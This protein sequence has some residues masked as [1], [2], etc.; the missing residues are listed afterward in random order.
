MGF[1]VQSANSCEIVSVSANSYTGALTA[2][3]VFKNL[4]TNTSTTH[5]LTYS[6]GVGQLNILTSSLGS[7]TGVFEVTLLEGGVEVARRPLLLHCD[8]DC[9]LAKLTNEI[10]DCACDCPKCSSALAKAQ[11]VFLLL[12]SALS[13]VEL[14][15]T[16]AGS[17][18]SGYYRDI[19][20]KYNKAR[21]ICDNSCG[22]NC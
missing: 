1:I 15:S 3:L 2:D 10:I 19:L 14:A 17:V 16:S 8:I 5:T 4:N 7:D 18:N 22:C 11:K 13:T 9:C 21:S 6:S 20:E 12:Q